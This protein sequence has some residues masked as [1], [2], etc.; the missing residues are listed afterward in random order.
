MF[1]GQ[2]IGILADNQHFQNVMRAG[3]KI[4]AVLTAEVGRWVK[5][6]V[7]CSATVCVYVCVCVC[8][9]YRCAPLSGE[10]CSGGSGRESEEGRGKLRMSSLPAESPLPLNPEEPR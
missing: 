4:R 7:V 5:G 1:V 9:A 3:F 8:G 2:M 10:V 6:F